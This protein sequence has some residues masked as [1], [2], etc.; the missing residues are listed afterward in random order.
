[1][2]KHTKKMALLLAACA[3]LGVLAGCGGG[4]V[5]SDVPVADIVTAVDAVV[6]NG[7]LVP[8]DESYVQG[9]LKVDTSL[10]AEYTVKINSMGT[11]VDEYGVFKAK[12]EDSAK[13]LAENVQAYLDERLATW[14]DEYM[15]EEKPKVE[16]AEVRT[17]GQ[18]V[19]YAI[20]SDDAK[21]AVFGALSDALK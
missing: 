17:E 16:N 20:L 15:P 9:R 6:G 5:R 2:K 3:L 10:C 4:D 7:S 11:S 19:M 8:V 18:Y 13:T 12:D 21:E 14:M 1:M